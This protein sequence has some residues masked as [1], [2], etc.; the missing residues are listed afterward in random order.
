MNRKK[1]FLALF[2]TVL[3]FCAVAGGVSVANIL[4]GSNLSD[5][6]TRHLDKPTGEK[7][8]IWTRIKP[9]PIPL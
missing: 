7:V 1:F 6:I 5:K 3:T 9:A 4:Y 2:V 8:N